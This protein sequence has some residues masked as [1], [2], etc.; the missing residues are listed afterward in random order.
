MSLFR[1]W[2]PFKDRGDDRISVFKSDFCDHP[3]DSFDRPQGYQSF[4]LFIVWILGLAIGLLLG[5]LLMI[6]TVSDPQELVP[7]VLNRK[8]ARQGESQS[9][10][11]LT[12]NF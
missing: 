10:H 11:S 3:V 7:G 4:L 8:N 12:V 5:Y 2:T 1:H 6:T 9:V